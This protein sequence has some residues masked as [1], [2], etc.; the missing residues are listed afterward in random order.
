MTTFSFSAAAASRPVAVP[1]S[2]AKATA[3]HAMSA[4]AFATSSTAPSVAMG[5]RVEQYS[6][7]KPPLSTEFQIVFPIFRTVILY[8]GRIVIK[9]FGYYILF[10]FKNPAT[11]DSAK[12]RCKMSLFRR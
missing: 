11:N 5:E 7:M 10:T 8:S 3:S 12:D 6:I 1:F 4:A 9:T 2:T